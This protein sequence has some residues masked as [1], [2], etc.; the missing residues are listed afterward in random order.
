MKAKG[1][2]YMLVEEEDTCTNQE[3]TQA[4]A[5]QKGELD[6]SVSAAMPSALPVG[7]CNAR[8]ESWTPEN[9]GNAYTPCYL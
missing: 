5:M 2:P 9:T 4:P 7:G 3:M 1:D 6:P 8:R